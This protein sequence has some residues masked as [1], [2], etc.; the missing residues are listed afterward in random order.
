MAQRNQRQGQ[1]KHTSRLHFER[2]LAC[3]GGQGHCLLRQS[4][5]PFLLAV[6]YHGRERQLLMK[7]TGAAAITTSTSV[8]YSIVG[9]VSGQIHALAGE[10]P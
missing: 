2:E 5:P 8:T 1:Q 9:A 6:S 10:S 7:W 3:P 4:F